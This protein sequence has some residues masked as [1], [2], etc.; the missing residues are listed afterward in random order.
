M[1]LTI[2]NLS[3]AYEQN[4]ELYAAV[5]D[6]SLSLAAGQTYGLVGES[7]SGK[8]TV[9]MAIMQYLGAGGQVTNGSIEFEGRNLL[10]LSRSELNHILGKDI[11][12]VP[13]DPMSSLNPSLRIGEQIAEGLRHHLSLSKEQ[14]ARQAVELLQQVRVPD[15]ARVARSYPHELSGGMQQ[16]VLIAMAISAEPKLIILDEP[17]TSLDVTTQ[18]AVLDLLRD[19]IRDRKTTLL[20]ITHNLGVVAQICDRVAVLYAGELVEDSETALLFQN[21]LHPYSKGLLESVPRLGQNKSDSRLNT[22]SGTI[23]SLADRA[24]TESFS[25]CI[26]A[27]RCPLVLDICRDQRPLLEEATSERLVRCHRWAEIAAG[28]AGSFNQDIPLAEEAERLSGKGE[29]L[30][31]ISDLRVEYSISRSFFD[32]AIGRPKAA[33]KAVDDVNLSIQKGHTLGLVGESGSGKST[34]ARAVVGLVARTDGE[35]AIS[36]LTLPPRLSDRDVDMLR[37]AQYVFQNPEEALNPYLTIGETLQRPFITLARQSRVDAAQRAREMLAAVGL[38]AEYMARLPGQLSGGEKQRVAIA[39][40]FA[41]NPDLLV[42][43]EPV[44]SLDVSVQAAILN[45]MERL[46]SANNSTLLFISHDLAV[47]GY[48]ADQIAVIYAGQIVEYSNATELFNLPHHPYTEALLSSVPEVEPG[49][50]VESIRLEGDVPSQIDVPSGCRFHPRC[51]RFLGDICVNQI[52]PW[53]QT[54]GDKG[55][56]CHIPLAELEESQKDSLLDEGYY[57]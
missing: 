42:A 40:A 28:E 18:A 39:R 52:P 45:L 16:R 33:I 31:D 43:D 24:T 47:V 7:G 22:I 44:S 56:L 25:R 10:A 11:T 38:P 36:G 1:M 9:A 34:L 20:Y 29:V 12:L 55:I 27:P 32:A 54:S 17:T 37:L 51:P 2:Q 26:F 48:L 4:G 5:R 30:L 23:P 19:L 13:Q 14:A 35:I 15:P 21:P 3:V 50:K 46:Q 41:T 57:K 8:S 6:F 49:R 53:Q